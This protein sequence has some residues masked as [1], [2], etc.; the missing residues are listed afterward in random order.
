MSSSAGDMPLSA[1]EPHEF[2]PKQIRGLFPTPLVAATVF[3]EGGAEVLA[4]ALRRRI[5]AR[6]SEEAGVVHSNVDGWQS[7]HDFTDWAGEPGAVLVAA[8]TRLVDRVTARFDGGEF[9]RSDVAW[10]VTAWA[11]VS[12]RGA[13]NDPHHHAGSFWS[14]VYYADD[15]G[16]DEHSGG[17]IEFFD[18]RGAL[19]MANAP[20]LKMTVGDCLT[21]GLAERFY[22]RSGVL[23]LFPAWLIHRVTRY[24]GDGVRVSVAMNFTRRA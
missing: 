9:R 21:A 11:N 12:R 3:D 13:A 8:A 17:A 5:L 6:E 14:A 7:G 16:S 15:G 22:P 23:L 4:E 19:A 20:D 10:D 18:P 24:T 2:A 1:F